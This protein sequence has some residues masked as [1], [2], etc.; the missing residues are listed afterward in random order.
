M[1]QGALFAA[2]AP[3][4]YVADPWPSLAGVRD[5]AVDFETTGLRWWAGDRPCG[6]AVAWK[7]PW[8][9]ALRSAYLPTGHQG[10]GNLPED[11]VRAWM[12]AELRGVTVYNLNTKFDAHMARAWGAPWEGVVAGLGDVGHRAALLDDHRQRFSLDAIAH[13]LLGEGKVQGVDVTRGAHVLPAG[14]V[15]PYAR[16]DAELVLRI[17]ERQVPDLAAQGLEDVVALEDSVI[18]VT[19]EMERNAFPIDVEKLHTWCRQSERDAT[20]LALQV[21]AEAGFAVNPDSPGDMARLFKARGLETPERTAGGSP[22]FADHVVFAAAEHDPLIAKVRALGQL[23]SLRSKFLVGYHKALSADGLMRYS[24]NQLRGERGGTVTGRFSASKA[25]R[26]HGE[27]VNV[28]QAFAVE[29]QVE[30]FGD[31]YVIRELFISARGSLL[32]AADAKQIQ[33]RIFA[34]YAASK[35]LLDAYAADP[36]T[37]FHQAVSD[38]LGGRY[39]RKRVKVVNFSNIFGA[40]LAKTAAQLGISESEAR[41]FLAEYNAAFPE[42]KALLR[43]AADVAGRQGYVRSKMRRRARFPDGQFLHAAL[44]RVIQMDE[45]DYVKL[46]LRELYD[47][48]QETGLVMRAMAHDEVVGDV[49]DAEAARRVGEILDRQSV[50]FRVPILWSVGT[51]ANWREAK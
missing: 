27:G 23:T 37:D 29:S 8:S 35:R 10:G 25:D 5:V 26:E 30:Q 2:E 11:R 7:D 36:E 44:N 39:I 12:R 31:R 15:A 28:Q 6:V 13:D 21:T 3:A 47:A 34:H 1:N 46:K 18:P 50:P 16:R 20:L 45:A 40:G 4:G 9:G 33:L 17:L 38:M 24:L 51:G 43:K 32:M 48:R 42:A 22:S 19:V 41:A 14:V 49:P